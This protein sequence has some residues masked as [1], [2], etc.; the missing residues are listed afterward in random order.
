MK[1]KNCGEEIKDGSLYCKYCGEKIGIRTNGWLICSILFFITTIIFCSLAYHYYHMSLTYAESMNNYR[2]MYGDILQEQQQ[3]TS[4]I[5]NNDV[6]ITE[7]KEQ[8]MK[9]ESEVLDLKARVPQIYHTKYANQ[10]LFYMKIDTFEKSGYTYKD[11]GTKLSIYTQTKGYGL[12][13][14]GWIPMDRLEH[15]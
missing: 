11:S 13:D 9:T 15:E 12:T 8:L 7:L 14:W 4:Q 2:A 10:D 6:K 5:K 1:C 3:Y